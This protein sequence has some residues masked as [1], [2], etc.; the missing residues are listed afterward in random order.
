LADPGILRYRDARFGAIAVKLAAGEH[1]VSDVRD[2]MIVTILG[3]CVAACIS[4][5]AAGVGGMNHFMLPESPDGRWGPASAHLRYGNF[6][7]ET[8]INDILR[9]GGQRSRLEAKVFGG[10]CVMGAG[11][12]GQCNGEFVLSYLKAEG[13]PVTAHDLFGEYPRRIHYFPTTGQ[14][15]MQ[16]LRRSCDLAAVAHES[17]YRA[18]LANTPVAGPIEVFD[19]KGQA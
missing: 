7:M 6:A 10:A 18:T 3:S 5:L 17:E 11:T 2:E 1:Y 13:V 14:A 4:D 16:A 15:H 19:A 9:R 12:I 8:L